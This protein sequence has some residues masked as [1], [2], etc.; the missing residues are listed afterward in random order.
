[1]SNA[2]PPYGL[3]PARLLCPWG[4]PGKNTERVCP[5]LLRGIFLTQGSKPC[6]LSLSALAGGFFTT[7]ATWE[8]CCNNNNGLFFLNEII[9]SETAGLHYLRILL[10]AFQVFCFPV[11][12][13]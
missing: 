4:S 10:L 6:L 9:L 3:Q 8:A 12:S 11:H 7:S 1:M 5:A 2:V 13:R